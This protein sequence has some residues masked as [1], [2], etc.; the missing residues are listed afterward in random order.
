M[1]SLATVLTIE[2]KDAAG[3]DTLMGA[4][5][6]D[7][8]LGEEGIDHLYGGLDVDNAGGGSDSLEGGIG[9]DNYYIV[10]ETTIST[11]SIFDTSGN[12][13]LDVQDASLTDTD[14]NARI[15]AL[16]DRIDQTLGNVTILAGSLGDIENL[17]GRQLP[18]WTPPSGFMY[19]GIAPVLVLSDLLT[20]EVKEDDS[21]NPTL[22]ISN[23]SAIQSLGDS[24]FYRL[25]EDAPAG[26]TIDETSGL[27]GWTPESGQ[28]G[29]HTFTVYATR[30]GTAILRSSEQVTITVANSDETP[31]IYRG[32]ILQQMEPAYHHDG[33]HNP[34]GD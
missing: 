14:T 10:E 8:L 4:A 33:N 34:C 32:L 28:E 31:T 20:T 11:V 22:S 27:I 9:D 7:M 13:T 18:T 19:D 3:T 26:M 15:I 12:D 2:S 29:D 5:G 16:D 17:D 25:G 23:L 6:N 24:V 21:W 30:Y 1:R